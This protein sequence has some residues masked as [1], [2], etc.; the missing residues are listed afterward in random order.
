MM[1][2]N[3]TVLMMAGGTGGHVFP[4]LA[5]SRVLQQQGY[6]IE[7]LGTERGI[8]KE[9]I[10]ANGI[11]LNTIDIAGLRGKG[12]LG[13]LSAPLRVSRAVMQALKIIRRLSPVA[14]VGFGGYATGPGGVAARLAGIPLLIHEQNA[15]AGMTN[16]LLSRLAQ[17]VMQAFPG[18]LEQA[19]TTGNPVREEVVN[20]PQ[21]ALRKKDNDGPLKVLVIGGSQ[22]AVALNNAVFAAMSLLPPEQRPLLIHQ[23][24]KNNIDKVQAEYREAGIDADVNAFIDDMAAAY[25]WADLLICRAGAST[26][27]EVAAAGCAALFIPLPSAV[28][29]HQTAN[30]RYLA[31]Q[32]A[33]IICAQKELTPQWLSELWQ[34]YAAD[35]EQLTAMATRARALAMADAADR[36]AEQVK[37]FARD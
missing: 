6:H 3:K 32:D 16:R 22:G 8:E 2:A 15:R 1:T 29:D 30:A 4:A 5:V 27:S 36:V 9:V 21:P 28:D 23:A 26:V 33:A 10:P 7:W 37:R 20:L 19:L 31:D 24:G 14:V 18:A 17:C 13:L 35:K 25:G 12:K 11:H 34:T